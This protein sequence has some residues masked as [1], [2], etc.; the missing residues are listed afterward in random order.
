MMTKQKTRS[1]ADLKL[2]II[3]PLALLLFMVFSCSQ[4]KNEPQSQAEPVAQE[5]TV[6]RED[7]IA[8]EEPV[9]QAENEIRSEEPVPE[10]DLRKKQING[11]D[12]FVVVEQMPTFMGGDV[13]YFRKWVMENVKYPEIAVAN[14]IQGKVFVA[15]VVNEDGSVSDI[16]ILRVVDPVLDN[17]AI[18]VVSSSPL[19]KPGKQGGKIVRVRFSI[20]V[21]FQLQ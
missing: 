7:L 11:R 5:E 18:R 1:V 10:H 8:Q 9:A 20:T 13:N 14:G 15:Y 6:A 2:L 21:N 19:W 16:E 3:A 12:V 17:E 4:E